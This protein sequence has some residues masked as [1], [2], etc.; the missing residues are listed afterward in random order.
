M[1]RHAP[2]PCPWLRRRR[3]RRAGSRRE[4]RSVRQRDREGRWRPRRSPRARRRVPRS[5]Y[6]CSNSRIRRCANEIASFTTDSWT[7]AEY[8]SSDAKNSSWFSSAPADVSMYSGSNT[9]AIDSVIAC[10]SSASGTG[11]RSSTTWVNATSSAIRDWQRSMASSKRSDD[12]WIAPTVTSVR[13]S[14][15]SRSAVPRPPAA[16][17]MSLSAVSRIWSAT[18][19]PAVADAGELEFRVA[20][21]SA[22]SWSMSANTRRTSVSVARNSPDSCRCVASEPRMKVRRVASVESPKGNLF[23]LCRPVHGCD[24][25]LE[26]SVIDDAASAGGGGLLGLDPLVGQ[27][28]D[29][30]QRCQE[31]REQ[32]QSEREP[33]GSSG[34]C[35]MSSVLPVRG[36]NRNPFSPASGATVALPDPVRRRT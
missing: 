20:R 7:P 23:E 9:S 25:L 11:S 21:A 4:R 1:P 6:G 35:H 13:L 15:P 22:R 30:Q 18:R 14:R 34:Q 19:S 24:V 10:D 28:S 26:S 31:E 29:A 27:H 12:R 17:S 16:D 36:L 8:T 3:S 5:W 32:A 33:C 2:D